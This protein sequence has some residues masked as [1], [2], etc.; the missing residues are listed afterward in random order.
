ME[1]VDALEQIFCQV[2]V[3]EL[4]VCFDL[5]GC[6]VEMIGKPNIKIIGERFE[7]P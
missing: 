6:G 4:E 5:G 3:Q 2:I 7:I 1:N